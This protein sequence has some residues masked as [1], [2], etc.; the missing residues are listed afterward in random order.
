MAYFNV[1]KK[2]LLILTLTFLSLPLFSNKLFYLSTDRT[3]AVDELKR[4]KV[5]S[6]YLSS[7]KIR[8][9]K[10]NDTEEYFLSQEDF[11]RPKVKGRKFRYVTPDVV[12]GFNSYLKGELRSWSRENIPSR[13]RKSILN[14]YSN[15]RTSSTEIYFSP[16]KQVDYIKDKN[17]TL[18]YEKKY[19]FE[20]RGNN[21]N[22]NYVYFNDLKPGTYLI[23]GITGDELA[24][25]VLNVSP[26]SFIT[27]KAGDQLQLYSVNNKT[28]EPVKDIEYTIYDRFRNILGRETSNTDG[29]ATATIEHND[30]FIVATDGNG[31]Y[32]FYDPRYYPSAVSNRTVYLYT[33]RPVY[34]GGD[35]INIKGII[36][37]IDRGEYRSTSAKEAVVSIW[38]QDRVI[39]SNIP[40]KIGDLGSFSADFIIPES[41]STGL[42]RVMAT[43][44][45]KDYEAEFKVEYYIKPEFK[46][47]VNSKKKTYL[48][49]EEINFDLKGEYYHG[50]PIKNAEINYVIS[51]TRYSHKDRSNSDLDFYLSSKEWVYTGIERLSSGTTTLDDNG[52]GTVTFTVD[53]A[54]ING[55]TPY[56]YML[57]ATVKNRGGSDVTASGS[58]RVVPVNLRIG[59]KTH[60]F[61][62]LPGESVTLEIDASDYD[63]NPVSGDFVAQIF[64]KSGGDKKLIQEFP[65]E[66]DSNGLSS[67]DFSVDEPGYIVVEVSGKDQKGN[68]VTSEKAIWIGEEGASYSVS[69]G[70]IKLVLDK[71]YYGTSDNAKLL[72]VSPIAD[73]PM[74][75]TIEGTKIYSSKIIRLNEN[76]SLINVPIK[77]E[78]LPNAFITVDFIYENRHYSNT[79]K[80]DIPP[81]EKFLDIEINPEQEIFSPD[82]KGEVKILVKD[83]TGKPV[84]NSEI[85]VS[86]VDEAIY[87]ISEELSVDIR[88]FFYHFRRNNVMTWTSSGFRF[89]GYAY[90]VRR[91]LAA[92]FYKD[93]TGIASFKGGDD[94]EEEERKDFKDAILWLPA[95]KTDNN[96]EAVIK[97]DFPSNITSWRIT[98]V[99][100]DG[101]NRFGV[102]KKNVITK[103]DIFTKISHPK[104]LGEYDQGQIYI[105]INNNSFNR[106][107]LTIKRSLSNLLGDSSDIEI[108][109]PGY[110]SY[111]LEQ[112]IKSNKP[113]RASFEIQ[114]LEGEKAHD[115]ITK[116]IE[117]NNHSLEKSITIIK[118]LTKNDNEIE[119]KKPID[120]NGNGSELSLSFINSYAGHINDSLKYLA[121]YPHGCVE[122]T[123][124]KFIPNLAIV[125]AFKKANLPLSGMEETVQKNIDTGVNRLSGYQNEDGSFGWWRDSDVNLYMTSYVLYA[126]S[127]ANNLS[128]SVNYETLNR[129]IDYLKENLNSGSATEKLFSIYVLSLNG[130][131]VESAYNSFDPESLSD[132][133]LALLLL[134]A[135]SYSDGAMVNQIVPILE[136]R[137]K[138]EEAG[139]SWGSD[140]TTQW[141]LDSIETTAW[142]LRALAPHSDSEKL[143]LIADYLISKK[144][145]EKWKS[146]RDTAV[147]IMALSEISKNI[148]SG[149]TSY[150]L[151]LNG[152]VIDGISLS[153]SNYNKRVFIDINRLEA[154]NT[155]KVT[156]LRDDITTV[157][158]NFKYHSN[159]QNILKGSSGASITR[160]YFKLIDNGDSY[161][162]GDEISFV[163]KG[164]NFLVELDY[165]Q[166]KTGE[167]VMIT[168]NYPA[169]AIYNKEIT[170]L[171]I[172]GINA[173]FPE[174]IDPRYG[175]I[176]FY[177]SQSGD[178]KI[179]YVLKANY[180]G[181]Y[182]V[183]PSVG[184]LMYFPDYRGNSESDK[185]I[186]KEESK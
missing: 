79:I 66:S 29:L 186:I 163:N 126:L 63:K 33:D 21:W 141:D 52:L 82:S 45:E 77:N 36:R 88:K 89:Y 167:Y 2:G 67:L 119:L 166:E 165:K 65:L 178:R 123:T 83:S 69:G 176:H 38:N 109:I 20:K 155:F 183:S 140:D 39:S 48:T 92:Q 4:V 13:N 93:A 154:N 15:L 118:K 99:V 3:Y 28:G 71:S 169:G 90:N 10:I 106:K 161:S 116:D 32:S 179:Y 181:E 98:A 164:E 14:K 87:A 146:T 170:P 76:S 49:G 18:A 122:Q 111:I 135:G 153:N 103:K 104:T 11:H 16:S 114:V 124:N 147:A 180:P 31:S 100:M 74:L 158:L 134:T 80:L 144:S 25:T 47:S 156:G 101:E 5:E 152:K 173:S 136:S 108:E 43:I 61:V 125:D 12:K 159:S 97:I 53:E 120:L 177:F 132:Y 86:V 168:D 117:V 62:Y 23:E 184:E 157:N 112:K 113:G 9:Y 172:A 84:K 94:K 19:V 46:V 105:N 40:V 51:R 150:F 128:Y 131:R 137:G 64:S 60:K 37:D 160:K 91:E 35:K 34:K 145:G 95:I 24:Y 70:F 81:L 85:S 78:Y 143:S 110:E 55:N 22:T 54:D 6:G 26:F 129:G 44:D 72:V 130:Y 121:M 41:A 59:L 148:N 185:F 17:F 42:Y 175:K 162:K 73:I 139:I 182:L 102:S 30:I 171:D 107:K 127:L 142:V 8:V 149:T 7:V 133:Q 174:S 151:E 68:M 27:K 75:L 50:E 115:H 57:S 138:E 58:V 1:A 96:G 56:T